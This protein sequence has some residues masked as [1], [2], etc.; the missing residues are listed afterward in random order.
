LLLAARQLKGKA[1]KLLSQADLLERIGPQLSA[2]SDTFTVRTYG[3]SVNPVT[4]EVQG[5]AW[6][7][8][9]VQRETAYVNSD[10][11]PALPITVLTAQENK[12]F[13]RR[14][15]VVSMRWLSPDDI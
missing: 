13:G 4:D 3:E 1:I 10:D 5:R 7:E 12:D 14:F 9:V 2:R 15:R 11:H 8:A 6:L